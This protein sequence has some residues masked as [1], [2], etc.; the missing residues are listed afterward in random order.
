MSPVSA[1]LLMAALLAVGLVAYLY[2]AHTVRGAERKVSVETL[3]AV[4]RQLQGGGVTLPG[5]AYLEERQV[6]LWID[7]V[8]VSVKLARVVLPG[9]RGLT[10]D[11]SRY[12]A[13]L[14]P[15]GNGTA[16]GVESKVAVTVSS[17]VAVVE[18]YTPNSTGLYHSLNI[19]SEKL[20][21]VAWASTIST[22][23]GN[24]SLGRPV[25]VV[26]VEKVVGGGP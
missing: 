1:A 21:L 11:P 16:C 2:A 22:P 9:C 3:E 25:E 12:N 19:T 5:G 14:A 7:E 17:S 18:Y 26:V 4:A 10:I 23:W 13:S 8:P 20:R 24:V 6:T 15:W